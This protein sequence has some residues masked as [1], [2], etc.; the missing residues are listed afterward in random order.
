MNSLHFRVVGTFPLS[1]ENG[2][3]RRGNLHRGEAEQAR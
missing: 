2:E 3:E 1:L